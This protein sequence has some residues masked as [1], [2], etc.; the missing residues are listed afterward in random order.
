MRTF[1]VAGSLA[2]VAAIIV[3]AQGRDLGRLKAEVR[4]G[5]EALQRLEEQRASARDTLAEYRRRAAGIDSLLSALQVEEAAAMQEA[6]DLQHQ[7]DSLSDALDRMRSEIDLASRAIVRGR[8]TVPP[9]SALLMPKEEAEA[10]IRARLVDRWILR[11]RRYIERMN[12]AAL[13]TSMQ[14]TRLR[15]AQEARGAMVAQRRMELGR[16][17]QR[18]RGAESSLEL[19]EAERRALAQIV[20]LKNAEARRIESLVAQSAA[21]TARSRGDASKKT[22]SPARAETPP[23]RRETPADKTDVRT[24]RPTTRRHA[25]SR[26][27]SWPS[28]SRVVVERY[29]ERKNPRTGTVT[30]NPG[31]NIAA[32][33]GSPALAAADGT[34]S[35]VSW[36]PSYG[37]VVIVEHDGG[38]RTVYGNLNASSV[39]RGTRVRVGQPLGTVRSSVDGDVLHFEVWNG[40]NRVNPANVVR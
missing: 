22:P 29:G 15:Q 18:A 40:G 35:L 38:W 28:S 30:M 6:A 19:K 2:F 32:P 25:S 14:D 8:L 16:L 1:V 10:E 23:A 12:N 20:E 34:V 3:L 31:I 21:R 4:R 5:R 37:T 26:T 11:G 33:A 9:S 39:P 27:F 13:T 36:L 17:L 7:R 24:A